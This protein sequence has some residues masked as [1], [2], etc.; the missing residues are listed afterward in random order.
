MRRYISVRL[1]RLHHFR[2]ARNE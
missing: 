1:Y 2:S